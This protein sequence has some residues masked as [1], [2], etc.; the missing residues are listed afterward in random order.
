MVGQ[1][2]QFT[3]HAADPDQD[4]LTYS[5]AGKPGAATLTA[6]TV[7][8]TAQFSWTPTT[9]DLGDHVVSFIVTDNGNGDPTQVLSDR[10]EHW[11]PPLPTETQRRNTGILS[12]Y[13]RVASGSDR[14]ASLT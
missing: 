7:Y 3:L 11:S 13:S 1:P 8:G 4:T 6:G 5:A 10:R 9:A 14:G 2:L 12:L